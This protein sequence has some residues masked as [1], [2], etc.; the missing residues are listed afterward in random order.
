MTRHRKPGPECRILT[1]RNPDGT[2]NVYVFDP[3]RGRKVLIEPNVP[4]SRVDSR[5]L[6]ARRVNLA[7]GN[8]VSFA[9]G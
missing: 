9:E 8:R 1:V 4:P 5:V 2:S 6:E 7:S 3:K